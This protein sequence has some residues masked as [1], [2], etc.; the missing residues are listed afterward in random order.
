V[1]ITVC[2]ST[3][4]ALN[5]PHGGGHLWVYLNWALG[6]RAL[7]CEVIWLETISK[8][9]SI[10]ALKSRRKYGRLRLERDG[11]VE[12]DSD[13]VHEVQTNVA[14][15]KRRLK[16]YGLADNLALHSRDGEA[17]SDDVTKGC[18]D[19]EAA[20][21]ADL[22]LNLR[23]NLPG[24]VVGRFRRSA[25]LD[26]DPG[27]LQLWM[28]QGLVGVSQHDLYFTIGET[29]GQPGALFPDLGLKWHYTPPPVFLPEWPQVEAEAVAPYTTVSHW[30]AM[31][32]IKIQGEYR[33]NNK[34]AAFLAYSDLPSR[35]PTP[36]ELALCLSPSDQEESR[37]LEERGWKIR[38]AWTVS[39]EPEQYRA[40]IQ[41]SR[42]EFSVVKPS[43]VWLSNAW[44]SDRTLCYLASAKPAVIQHTGPS[45]FLPDS[46]GLLR[47]RTLEEAAR[48]LCA[49]EADYGRHCRLARELAE[50]HFD[51]KKV[52]GRVLE[53]A[54]A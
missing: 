6:L 32:W 43:C 3:N 24:E 39:S 23:Y 52:L 31:E 16:R 30:W 35:T 46:E 14:T 20:A 13:L 26:I 33:D 49:V 48:A 8:K 36:L 15:L 11:H 22:L 21:E 28:S 4:Q 37:L 29:V 53:R 41:Q 42:G 50:E 25:L 45:R 54:L 1:S 40:Y 2:L 9:E 10:S 19:F 44:I 17:L 18:L 47:F 51:A 27:L 34:R 5:Y 38:H 12:P 7:G